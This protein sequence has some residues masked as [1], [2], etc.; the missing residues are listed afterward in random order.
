MKL[1]KRIPTIEE[2]ESHLE[3]LLRIADDLL[4]RYAFFT[5]WRIRGW[6][7]QGFSGDYFSWPYVGSVEDASFVEELAWVLK[8]PGCG[9][10]EYSYASHLRQACR[11]TVKL[12]S[13]PESDVIKTMI[14][15]KMDRAVE[16]FE[17]DEL[18]EQRLVARIMTIARDFDIVGIRETWDAYGLA[19]EAFDGED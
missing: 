7:S 12:L 15:W 6:G 17:E 19:H 13:A 5:L 2:S 4:D 18:I 14:C 10:F 9:Q 1:T 16:D 8:E 11:Q 3:L